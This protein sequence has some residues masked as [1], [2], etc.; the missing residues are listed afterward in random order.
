MTLNCQFPVSHEVQA[1][2]YFQGND[3]HICAPVSSCMENYNL[4]KMHFRVEN[5]SDLVVISSLV[6]HK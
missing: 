4:S 3:M 2:L 5:G 6:L 1:I